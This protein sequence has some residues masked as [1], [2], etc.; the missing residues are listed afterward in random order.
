MAA[1]R[2]TPWF[3]AGT[4]P[5]RVGVYETRCPF[6]PALP[7]WFQR[8]DGKRWGLT[9]RYIECAGDFPHLESK[10]RPN[11]EWRGLTKEAR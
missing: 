9:A 3:P 10:Q 11:P 7:V 4:K 8:W 5:V 1:Q 6:N 2:K